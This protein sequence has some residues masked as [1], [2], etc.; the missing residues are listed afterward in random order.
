MII[1]SENSQQD[2]NFIVYLCTEV[3]FQILLYLRI[4][5]NMRLSF[6][7]GRIN[8]IVYSSEQFKKHPELSNLITNKVKLCECFMKRYDELMDRLSFSF[9]FVNCLFFRY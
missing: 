5:D 6:V 8:A 9:S 2:E 3:W 4:N 1:F 7:L